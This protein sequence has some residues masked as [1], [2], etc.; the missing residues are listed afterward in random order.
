MP[1]LTPLQIGFVPRTF[2]NL[3]G[4]I[5]N[6][7]VKQVIEAIGTAGIAPAAIILSPGPNTR[8]AHNEKKYQALRQ[9]PSVFL[10]YGLAFATALIVGR[11]LGKIGWHGFLPSGMN[12]KLT[13]K[14]ENFKNIQELFGSIGVKN[15][16][17]HLKDKVDDLFNLS[18]ELKQVET[19]LEK[20]Q[21]DF[22][23]SL[24]PIKK[25]V[26]S[27]QHSNVR[28]YI[29]NLEKVSKK[30]TKHI[31]EITKNEQ[32]FIE[33]EQKVKGIK[34]SSTYII[35]DLRKSGALSPQQLEQFDKYVKEHTKDTLKVFK[36]IVQAGIAIA[37]LPVS[38]YLLNVVYPPFI[39]VVAPGLA[40]EV[41]EA[42]R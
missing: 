30:Y 42:N 7:S 15:I 14:T 32:E 24:D 22:E 4:K 31:A 2:K 18:K 1:S 3:G 21:F 9:L 11:K 6:E 26:N 35:R 23:I 38:A 19:Q 8:K 29:E 20:A 39:K 13:M 33:L 5:Q 36:Q 37:S 34:R 16:P 40:K 25:V 10:K 41:E 12:S 17:A 27:L 28:G